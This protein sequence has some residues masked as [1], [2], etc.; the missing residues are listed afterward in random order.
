MKKL[1]IF[2]CDGVLVDSEIIAN[3]IDAEALTVLGYPLT[4]EESISR[5]TGMNS[6][7]VRKLIFEESGIE[8]PDNFSIQQQQN[9]CKAFETELAPLIRAANKD[10]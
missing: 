1:I 10:F 3:R 7:S 2:D 8:L 4:A 6:Q 5:F 9:I